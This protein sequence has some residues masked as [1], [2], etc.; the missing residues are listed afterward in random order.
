MTK[1]IAFLN[2]NQLP[3]SNTAHS[4]CF[5]NLFY[6]FVDY[7]NATGHIK[8][9]I[10]IHLLGLSIKDEEMEGPNANFDYFK[11]QYADK[12]SYLFTRR[13]YRSKG[14][15]P[16]V[17]YGV[18]EFLRASWQLRKYLKTNRIDTLYCYSDLAL[19]II[20]FSL[21][22]K[23]KF[24][25]DSKGDR[26]GE[27]KY[28]G[29]S[30]LFIRVN[31]IYQNFLLRRMKKVFISSSKLEELYKSQAK[32]ATFIENTNYY[33]DRF[34]HD[35]KAEKPTG[36][37]RF[38]YAGSTVR[39]QLIDETLLLFRHYHDL[40][41]NSELLL[42]IR[43]DHAKVKEKMKEAGVSPESVILTFAASLDELNNFLNTCDIAIMLRESFLIN[44]YAFPTKFAEY[45]AT[46]LPVIGT[47]GVYDTWKMITQ[48]DLGVIVDL[49]RPQAEEVP[50]V[51]DFI[52]SHDSG[53]RSHC[54]GWA[55]EHLS[56]SHNIE[57]I[58]NEI[59]E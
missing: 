32:Q 36:K 49:D 19:F 45:L 6:R 46:G 40:F 26:I 50:K 57:R 28:D 20:L 1:R 38:V 31:D 54:A 48:N 53:F 23:T 10:E 12:V 4:M 8:N 51:H 9:D 44:Y 52:I 24:F 30:P 27:M 34:F 43:D 18:L 3:F 15:G 25:F 11:N 37:I 55:L 2:Y 21:T 29:R 42:L 41:P 22:L 13:K 7:H 17:F 56:W 14:K 47:N 16:S 33:D 58:Y 35:R 5:S 59:I 39:Y